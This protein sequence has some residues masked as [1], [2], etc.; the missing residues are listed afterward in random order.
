MGRL[1]TIEQED[2]FTLDLSKVD[3]I[4]LYLL[5][6]MNKK[7]VS[8]LEKLKPGARVVTHDYDLEGIVADESVTMHSLEDGVKHYI[9]QYTAPL[10]KE[11]Q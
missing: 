4:M 5:P 7:L 9:Y 10:K 8:Q 11:D 6:S 1:V 3:V 2:I